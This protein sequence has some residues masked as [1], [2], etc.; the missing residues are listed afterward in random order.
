MAD[1][2]ESNVGTLGKWLACC[3]SKRCVLQVGEASWELRIDEWFVD[4]TLWSEGVAGGCLLVIDI[5]A[6]NVEG[7]TL[8]KTGSGASVCTESPPEGLEVEGLSATC[9]SQ[10]GIG[11]QSK[12]AQVEEVKRPCCTGMLRWRVWQNTRDTRNRTL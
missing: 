5:V 8:S 10:S 11:V 12:L 6:D 1:I 3:D 2:V 9:W 4:G 7:A